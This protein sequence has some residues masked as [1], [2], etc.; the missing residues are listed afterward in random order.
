MGEIVIQYCMECGAYKL[1]GEWVH[2]S[3]KPPQDILSHGYCKP[4]A[5]IV[6]KRW[7]EQLKQLKEREQ[8]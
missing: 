6:R 3:I 5:E 7:R 2:L 4:C 1:Q 8:Q